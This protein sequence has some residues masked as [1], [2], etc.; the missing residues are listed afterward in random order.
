[1]IPRHRRP[2]LPCAIALAVLTAAADQGQAQPMVLDPRFRIDLVT[3]QI[4]FPVTLAITPDHRLLVSEKNTGRIRVIKNGALL[5]APFA[6]VPVNTCAERGGLGL[7]VDPNFASNGYVYFF[8]TRSSTSLD[9][10]IPEQVVDNRIVRFTADGDTA[11]AGSETL[12]ISLPVEPSLCSH[13]GGNVHFGPD[14]MLF[15]S[16]GDG[17]FAA[18]PALDL[19]T[20]LGKIL[21]LDPATGAAAADN[22]FA[23]DGDPA[24]RAEIWAYGLRNSFDF[25]IRKDFYTPGDPVTLFATENGVNQDDEINL[26]IEGGDYGFPRVAGFVDTAAESA[27]RAAH[28]AYRDPLWTSGTTVRCPTGIAEVWTLVGGDFYQRAVYWGQCVNVSGSRQV[29]RALVSDTLPGTRFGEEEIFATGFGLITDLEFVPVPGAGPTFDDT[30]YV[31]SWSRIDRISAISPEP[32]PGV[33]VPALQPILGLRHAG[34]HPA[35]GAATFRLA[36]PAG[37]EG[38]LVIYDVAGRRVW[39]LGEPVRGPSEVD[40]RWEGEDDDGRILPAGVYLARL[41]PVK[42]GA[43][44]QVLRFVHVR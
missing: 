8:Y 39:G 31:V 6:D 20:L 24:T 5:A 13:N 30:M 26:I 22:R 23:T 32:P 29:M 33:S 1:M 38:R 21:R 37:I 40:V 44:E 27:Y 34:A 7:A 28:P 10:S 18:S 2:A 19:T 11:L 14:G 25:T 15:V 3:N 17:N 9:S 41:A 16:V 36:V 4:P 35:P 42:G 12:L 43:R